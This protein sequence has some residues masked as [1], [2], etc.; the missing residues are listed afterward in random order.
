[1]ENQITMFDA[2]EN[3]GGANRFGV[4][5]KAIDSVLGSG[6]EQKVSELALHDK[7]AHRAARKNMQIH[8]AIIA[9]KDGEFVGFF[10][11]QRN[12][13]AKEFCFLQSALWDDYR[14][15]DLYR[16][17]VE[18]VIEQNTDGYPALITVGRKSDL[19]TPELFEGLGFK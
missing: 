8:S 17:M 15:K 19:E 11:F 2:Q 1:M 12:H 3:K 5:F 4:T 6:Y 16:Q 7:V 13:K 18:A 14:D 10:T 9:E